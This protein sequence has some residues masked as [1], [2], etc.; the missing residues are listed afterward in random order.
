M[1]AWIGT[2]SAQAQAVMPAPVSANVVQLAASGFLDVQQ[3]WMTLRL[4]V[5]REG[6][7]AAQVQSQLRTALDSALGIAKGAAA[8]QQLLVHSGNFGVYARYDKAG[9]VSGWQGQ[10][11]LVL[12]GRDFT[13]IA[14]T[15]AQMQPLAVSNM[16]FSL[17]REAQQQL[18]SDVQALAIERFQR[19]AGEVA[20][21]FGFG[22]YELKEVSISS[23]D[24]GDERVFRRQT[25][26]MEA[27]SS[28]D[29]DP[30]PAEPGRSQLTVTVSGAVQLK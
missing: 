19:R 20:K 10:G 28:L 25:M 6:A 21:A 7:D 5:T 16:V 14:R 18:E 13:R 29:K 3:D 15:A 30:L 8:E 27:A 24:T 12:E 4:S 17:S 2:G 22:A 26:A 9:K 23:A 11:E 1:L